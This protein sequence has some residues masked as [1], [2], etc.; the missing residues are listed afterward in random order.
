MTGLVN[1][2]PLIQFPLFS[3][4]VLL[5]SICLHAFVYDSEEVYMSSCRPSAPQ[6]YFFISQWNK[7]HKIRKLQWTVQQFSLFY[8][9][10]F[11]VIILN[12]SCS[13]ALLLKLHLATFSD[14]ER[15]F[16]ASVASH[17]HHLLS[18]TKHRIGVLRS[19]KEVILCI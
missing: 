12:V 15:C 5:F 19:S 16:W 6:V 10:L 3:C 18:C 13:W 11:K 8:R 1:L 14:W 2:K 17:S 9:L 4:Q 7:A